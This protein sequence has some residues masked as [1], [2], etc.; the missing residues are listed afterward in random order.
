[1]KGSQKW[2]PFLFK[3][4]ILFLLVT[5]LLAHVYTLITSH[6]YMLKNIL[7]SILSYIFFF[8]IS[9]IGFSQQLDSTYNFYGTFNDGTGSVEVDSYGRIIV[10]GGFTKYKTSEIKYLVRLFPDGSIDPSFKTGVVTTPV[11]D[12]NILS[13]GKILLLSNG[14]IRLN[15]DG[16]LDKSFSVALPYISNITVL[17][18]SQIVVTGDFSDTISPGKIL[19]GFAILKENGTIDSSFISAVPYPSLVVPQ[20]NGKIIVVGSSLYRLNQDGSI[21]STFNTPKITTEA[22]IVHRLISDVSVQPDGKVLIGGYFDLVNNNY[23]PTFARLNQDGSFDT[24]FIP[25]FN[26]DDIIIYNYTEIGD[27][28]IEY[29][30]TDKILVSYGFNDIYSPNSYNNSGYVY[31]MNLHGSKDTTFTTITLNEGMGSFYQYGSKIY[32][33]GDF[34][35]CN[36]TT[37]NNFAVCDSNGTIDQNF[38]SIAGVSYYGYVQKI[39]T[40]PNGKILVA[41][42]G[43]QGSTN[44]GNSSSDLSRLLPNGDIDTSFHY[45]NNNI[46]AMDIYEFEY[47]SDGKILTVTNNKGIKNSIIRLYQDGLIDSTYKYSITDSLSV[48]YIATLNDSIT[49]VSGQYYNLSTNT[50]N[51][52]VFPLVGINKDGSANPS[53]NHTFDRP[54]SIVTQADGKF[55]VYGSFT[56]VDG[57]DTTGLIRFN[58][59]GAMDTSFHWSGVSN[60]ATTISSILVLYNQK[61]LVAGNFTSYDGKP[62]QGV[63]L[64]HNDGNYDSTFNPPANLI[65]VFQRDSNSIIFYSGFQKYMMVDTTGVIADSLLLNNLPINAPYLGYE[66]FFQKNDKERFFIS[67]EFYSAIDSTT[68]GKLARVYYGDAPPMPKTDSSTVTATVLTS[69]GS[70]SFIIYPNPT[71]GQVTISYSGKSGSLSILGTD[72]RLIYKSETIDLTNAKADLSSQSPGLYFIQVQ[73]IEGIITQKL[74]IE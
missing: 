71:T 64:L 1:M 3:K 9:S 48:Q 46:Y 8:F 16:S 56:K 69:T 51:T 37:K 44:F 34:G 65:P 47:L 23:S 35:D 58:Q 52:S 66:V 30:S 50:F 68:M 33:T 7:S 12:I 28:Q 63:V 26:E 21:D 6:S 20:N 55:I 54:I 32:L 13:D 59:D 15:E 45:H 41:V 24:T 74:I 14:L 4:L 67:G 29:T 43:D 31:R 72:G 53:Y 39:Q 57:I 22:S 61:L 10:G 19:K 49:L 17:S 36:N 18:D 42:S 40:L 60:R 25:F 70:T 2:E 11:G 5:F 27:I 38:Y 62:N 73:T